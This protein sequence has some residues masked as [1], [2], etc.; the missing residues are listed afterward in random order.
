MS[1]KHPLAVI[2]EQIV[3]ASLNPMTSGQKAVEIDR[4]LER[5][6]LVILPA[7]LV[8]LLGLAISHGEMSNLTL[9][10]YLKD[11][12]LVERVAFD[13]AI[14]SDGSEDT[15]PGDPYLVYGPAI[16]SVLNVAKRYLNRAL[17]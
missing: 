8:A 3:E 9:L 4:A 14:H 11:H 5:A 13:P 10:S 2:R 12:K 1:H 15:L 6:G 16:V 17:H 7:E